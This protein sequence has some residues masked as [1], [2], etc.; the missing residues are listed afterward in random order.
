MAALKPLV[1]QWC[2][3]SWN[4]LRERKQLILDGW[5]RSCLQLFDITSD[6]RRVEA[7]ELAALN[8]LD[9][10]ALPDGEEHDDAESEN[11]DREEDELD[12]TKPRQFGRQSTREKATPK[13]FGY[14][15]DPTRVE[16]DM[17]PAP[18]AAAAAAAR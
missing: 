3:D 14:F 13:K 5:S 10:Q 17:E 12:I 18:A 15:V 16:I 9:I 2:V 8:K 4:G 7:V 6:K 1:L 11:S